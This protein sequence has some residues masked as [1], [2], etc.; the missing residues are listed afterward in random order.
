M[1]GDDKC[2]YDF[3]RDSPG[4]TAS[5]LPVCG[6]RPVHPAIEQ[7]ESGTW[8]YTHPLLHQDEWVIQRNKTATGEWQDHVVAW[9]YDDGVKAESDA[10]TELDQ[11][12]RGRATGDGSFVRSLRVGDVVTVWAKARFPGWVNHIESV[13]MEVYWAV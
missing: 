10:S 7:D 11:Q 2:T 12:G 3:G 13:K 6:L 4:S 5:K 1:A 9:S 8:H